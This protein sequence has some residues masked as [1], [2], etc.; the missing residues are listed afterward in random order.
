[1]IDKL[2]MCAI[3]VNKIGPALPEPLEQALDVVLGRLD[4]VVARWA[5]TGSASIVLQGH[6]MP[7]HDIDIQTTARGAYEIDRRFTDF[8]VRPAKYAEA[9]RIRS[10]FGTY[11]VDGVRVEVMGGLQTWDGARWLPSRG[12]M[13]RVVTVTL[14]SGA[15][16]LAV[17]L[18][19]E[20][21]AYRRLGRTRTA[22]LLE[23]ALSAGAG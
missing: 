20:L 11:L 12:R 1:M 19:V 17:D 3:R 6:P 9:D 14:A 10:H 4:G 2:A 16:V 7:V 18:R 22:D 5:I 21:A 23:R 8:V 13:P 15:P